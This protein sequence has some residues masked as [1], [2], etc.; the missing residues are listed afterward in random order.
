MILNMKIT[1]IIK[2][3]KELKHLSILRKK[4]QKEISKVMVS[5]IE[6]GY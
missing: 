6:E 1:N 3:L 5:E 4:N 2:L